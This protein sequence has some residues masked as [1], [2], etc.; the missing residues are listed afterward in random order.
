MPLYFINPI[1]AVILFLLVIAV[2]PRIEIR[3][4]AFYGIIF[5]AIIDMFNILIFTKVLGIGSYINYGPFEFLDIPFFPLISWVAYFILFFYF[6]PK[7]RPWDY[8]YVLSAASLSTMFS[9]ILVNLG[10]FKWNYGELF[11]PYMIYL[12]WFALVTMAYYKL[13]EIAEQQEITSNNKAKNE[14]KDNI[15]INDFPKQKHPR[16]SFN[17]SPRRKIK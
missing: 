12:T 16:L 11:V 17:L 8:I 6:L 4:L 10:V 2:V 3:R 7:E 1:V 9:N 15:P 14:D 13:N 5:G